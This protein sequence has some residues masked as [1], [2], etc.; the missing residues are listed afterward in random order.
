[1]VRLLL[2]NVCA[3]D[4]DTPSILI[5]AD[6]LSVLALSTVT[7]MVAVFASVSTTHSGAEAM[8]ADAGATK[9]QVKTKL[10]VFRFILIIKYLRI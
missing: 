3:P 1:M 8:E 5:T 6:E 10:A 9:A 7:D 4:S 2:D